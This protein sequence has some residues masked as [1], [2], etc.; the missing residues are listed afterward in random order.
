WAEGDLTQMRRGSDVAGALRPA[1]AEGGLTQM[2]RGSDAPGLSVGR[3]SSLRCRPGF[4]LA[5]GVIGAADQRPRLHVAEAELPT[6][7]GQLGE[8]VGVVVLLDGQVLR[9][10]PEVLA[11][12]QD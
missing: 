9:R 1:W 2:R 8:L 12:R 11:E 7:H 4:G 10:R 3:Q 5:L 6:H